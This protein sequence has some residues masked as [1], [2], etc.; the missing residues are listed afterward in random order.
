[1]IDELR[2]FVAVVDAGSLSKAARLKDVAVSSVTRKIDQLEAEL[3]VKLLR[4]SSRALTLTDAGQQFIVSARHILNELDDAKAA[5]LDSET[6]VRGI[7][8]VTAPSSFGRRHVL[9]ATINFMA[10]Y[11]QIEIELHLNDHLVDLV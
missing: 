4:R 2:M 6:N 9:P 10:L 3:G 5:L 1:M 11:P 8:T 7:L